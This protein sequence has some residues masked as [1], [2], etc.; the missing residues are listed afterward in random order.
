MTLNELEAIFGTGR[1]KVDKN[2]SPYLTLHTQVEAQFYL[3]AE[4][5]EDWE[6]I[7]K[8]KA[9]GKIPVF[10]IGGGSN[11]AILKEKIEGL[12]VKNLYQKKEVLEE[13][14]SYVDLLVS[15]GYPVARIVTETAK[16]GWGGL[17]YHLGLPGTVGGAIFMN[18]KWTRPLSYFGDSLIYA[19]IIDNDGKVKKVDRDYFE[20]AYDYS[21]L[22][23][24][25]E[26]V[27]EAVFRLKK[28]NPEV[29]EQRSRQSLLYRSETQPIGKATCGCFFRNISEKVQKELNLPF[30]SAGY[31]IDKAGLKNITVGDFTI[32]DKHA[33]FII[34][35]GQ[36][37]PEDL[38]KLLALIKQ[39]VKKK[40]G[41][42]LKEEVIV[43]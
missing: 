41:V 42:E 32:S 39:K 35:K 30:S 29:L 9:S 6:N 25:R 11:V 21:I 13:M 38:K 40:F 24:T 27:V 3:E 20:F 33:N 16:N 8:L 22:H 23:K 15:S 10:I 14:D 34:N 43:V 17:E 2:L 4:S 31:L 12:T 1:V 7:G 18:S 19:Y 36:G 28:E 26:I 5:R 37:K